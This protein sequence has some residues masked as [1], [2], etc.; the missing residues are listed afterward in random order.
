MMHAMPEHVAH[1]F[2]HPPS[3]RSPLQQQKQQ[4]KQQPRRLFADM[5]VMWCVCVAGTAHKKCNISRWVCMAYIY[6]MYVCTQ[7]GNNCYAIDANMRKNP[8]HRNTMHT[9]HIPHVAVAG[10]RNIAAVVVVAAVG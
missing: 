6:D 4:H 10:T 1:K 9:E 3:F 5:I 2:D 7:N 8:V